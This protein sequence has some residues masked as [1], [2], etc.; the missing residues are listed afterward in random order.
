MS[1]CLQSC[2][3]QSRHQILLQHIHRAVLVLTSTDSECI[4]VKVILR[5]DHSY[6][7][8]NRTSNCICLNYTQSWKGCQ[9]SYTL[10]MYNSCTRHVHEKIKSASGQMAHTAGAAFCSMKQ[11]EVFLLSPWIGCQ[12]ITGLLPPPPPALNTPVPSYTRGH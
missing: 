6:I 9:P 7:K 4:S 12:C 1:G 8:L 11:I 10:Q 3:L 5:Q 2:F